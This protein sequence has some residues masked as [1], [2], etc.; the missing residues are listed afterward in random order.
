LASFKPEWRGSR[1]PLVFIISDEIEAISDP[2][3]KELDRG[4]TLIKGVGMY[5]GKEHGILMRVVSGDQAER[6]RE[7]VNREDENAFVV[8]TAAQDVRG[9]G[10]RP[11]EA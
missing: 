1:K 8:V 11:L 4:I 2:L 7:I 9:E 3:L 5:S 6:L 10:F